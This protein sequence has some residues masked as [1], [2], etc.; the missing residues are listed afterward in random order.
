MLNYFIYNGKVYNSGT[1]VVIRWCNSMTRSVLNT[2]A[3]F[4]CCNP[5]SKEYILEV[6]GER[7]TYTEDS[8]YKV[9]CYIEDTN[10]YMNN[11]QHKVENRTLTDELNIDGLFFAWI[12]YILIML[13]AVVFHARIGIWIFASIVFF[14]YRSNKLKEAGYK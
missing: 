2:K 9:L 4:I 3:K 10:H 13:I 6:Y 8:F 5:G 1:I 11:T 12:W 14:N 7:Y